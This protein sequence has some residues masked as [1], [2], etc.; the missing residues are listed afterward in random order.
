MIIRNDT[1]PSEP[2]EQAED[3]KRSQEE[4]AIQSSHGCSMNMHVEYLQDRFMLCSASARTLYIWL[5][6]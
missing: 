6:R 3:Q 1:P 5:L 2:Q 4:G